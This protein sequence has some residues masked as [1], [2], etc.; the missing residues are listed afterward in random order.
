M[1]LLQM[2]QETN[3]DALTID[4]HDSALIGIGGQFGKC[5]AVYDR[6]KI[7]DNL[8]AMG[9]TAEEATEYCAYNIDG[10]WVGDNTPIIIDL[11]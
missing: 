3:P 10:A 2:L 8:L 11:W 1:T 9:M 4:G 6:A 5:L 7:I